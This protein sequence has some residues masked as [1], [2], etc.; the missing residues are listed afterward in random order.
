MKKTNILIISGLLTLLSGCHTPQHSNT[1]IF[2]TNT[3]FGVDVGYDPKTQEPSFVVGYR[4]QEG[5]WMPLLANCGADGLSPGASPFS[6]YQGNDSANKDTYSVLATFKGKAAGNG[7]N[8]ASTAIAQYF[9]TGLAARELAQKGGAALVSTA[10]KA[11]TD[12]SDLAYLLKPDHVTDLATYGDLIKKP[13]TKDVSTKNKQFKLPGDKDKTEEYGMYLA[14]DAGDSIQNIK[15]D[16]AREKDFKD[17]ISKLQEA[18][19]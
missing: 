19:K 6:L 10:A 11:P 4:R 9:A 2:A 7:T 3:R 12:K 16:P 15:S 18:T 13:L 17:I 14:Y 1:L 5:V 8:G